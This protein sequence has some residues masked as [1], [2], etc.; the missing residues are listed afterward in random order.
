MSAEDLNVFERALGYTKDWC[1]DHQWEIGAAEMALGSTA[2]AWGIQNGSIE[3][4]RDIVATAFSHVNLGEQIG[5]A[6]GAGLGGIGGTILGSIGVVAMGGAIGIPAVIVIGGGSLILGAA[7]YTLGDLINKFLNPPVDPVEFFG[8]ASVLAVGVALLID[9]ARRVVTDIRALE[10]A[11]K[12]KN[13]VIYL[14]DLAVDVVARSN[15]ELK[16]LV[17]SLTK[18]PEDAIDVTG[19]L[20]SGAAAAAVG[21]AVGGSL[22]AGS[23]T[24]LGS[25]AIGSV[26]LSIGLVSAPVWPV[27]AGGAAGLAL[28]YGAWKA[29]RHFGSRK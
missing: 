17:Q 1:K 22:A 8:N 25:Q 7:G 21:T 16:A 4:G 23:V 29:V 14:C 26:A 5:G 24:V 27:I 3:M 19:S 15:N 2:I 18:A 11:S 6:L 10:F 20:V 28:G 12:I 13:G 9:G